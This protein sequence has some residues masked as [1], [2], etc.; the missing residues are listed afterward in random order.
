[1]DKGADDS[2]SSESEESVY[3]G[4]EEEPGTSEEDQSQV[5][6]PLIYDI[7][8]NMPVQ[9]SLVLKFIILLNHKRFITRIHFWAL[10]LVSLTTEE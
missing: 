3:S 7:T 9:F 2:E 4:L 1:M 6:G 5:S 8:Y 10:S